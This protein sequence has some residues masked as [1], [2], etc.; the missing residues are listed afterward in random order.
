MKKDKK[1]KE[2]I[3]VENLIPEKANNGIKNNGQGKS[4]RRYPIAFI[5]KFGLPEALAKEG[6]FVREEFT[7]GVSTWTVT[8]S[9]DVSEDVNSFI[10]SYDPIPVKKENLIVEL[11]RIADSLILEIYNTPI[12][13]VDLAEFY[14][15]L[16][17]QFN[18]PG[19]TPERLLDLNLVLTTYGIKKL[20]V[21]LLT[22]MTQLENYDVMDGWPER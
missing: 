5:R 9:E 20:E 6:Y 11:K 3:E 13:N 14:S 19:D 16:D 22:T 10:Q 8:S 18:T 15:D 21:G 12:I 2:S 1:V 17:R 4:K 7:N